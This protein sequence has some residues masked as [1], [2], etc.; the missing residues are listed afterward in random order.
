MG[1][2]W[3]R[4]GQQKMES[5]S[6]A[7]CDENGDWL[8]VVKSPATTNLQL[9]KGSDPTTPKDDTLDINYIAWTV[10]SFFYCLLEMIGCDTCTRKLVMSDRSKGKTI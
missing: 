6:K 5:I 4:L 9:T 1:F 7:R 10:S 3:L 2:Q 8:T